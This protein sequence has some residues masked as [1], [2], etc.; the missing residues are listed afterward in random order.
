MCIPLIWPQDAPFI[1]DEPW[2]FLKAHEANKNHLLAEIGLYGTVGIPY[3]PVP[4]WIYQGLLLTTRSPSWW[5]TL[6]AGFM[7]VSIAIGLLLLS[8]ALKLWKWFIPIILASPYLWFYA[9]QIWDNSFILAFSAIGLGAYSYFHLNRSKV[10]LLLAVVSTSVL[11]LIHFMALPL[12]MA[13][14]LHMA[15]FARR[16]LFQWRLILLAY[17]SCFVI[18]HANY[19]GFLYTGLGHLQPHTITLNSTINFLRGWLFPLGGGRLLSGWGLDYFFGKDF[20]PHHAGFSVMQLVSCL[21]FVLVLFGVYLATKKLFENRFLF[22]LKEFFS[23]YTL[24]VDIRTHFAFIIV[25]SLCFQILECGISHSYFYPHYHN[26]LWIVDVLAAWFAVDRLVKMKWGVWMVSIYGASLVYI[27]LSIMA[28]V[29][30]RGG[31][32]GRHYGPTIGNQLEVV[33]ALGKQNTRYPVFCIVENFMK[34]PS[35]AALRTLCLKDTSS[36]QRD[37]LCIDY[38]S[39]DARSGRVRVV[40]ENKGRKFPDYWREE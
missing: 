7:I 40:K 27:L 8:R 34:Y 35:I 29:H 24:P 21:G 3:G 19:F 11:P 38:V 13:L 36:Q 16:E 4:T 9:R 5:I 22:P 32:R 26:G 10:F 1:Y 39:N 15:L 17:F 12:V 33:R 25:V 14:A 18:F 23:G 28:I 31:T 30:D 20:F 37:S 6:H 2:L